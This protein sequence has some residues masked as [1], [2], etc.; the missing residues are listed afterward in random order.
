MDSLTIDIILTWTLKSYFQNEVVE[1]D[2]AIQK[3]VDE[4]VRKSEELVRARKVEKNIAGAIENLSQCLPVLNTY[5]KLQKQM[6]EK[7]W[8]SLY[9][10]IQFGQWKYLFNF[11]VTRGG[12]SRTIILYRP[13]SRVGGLCNMEKIVRIKSSELCFYTIWGL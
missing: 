2:E 3:S 1:M 9:R 12:G 4:V 5:A 10:L 6:S 7:R 13:T 11:F 8:A